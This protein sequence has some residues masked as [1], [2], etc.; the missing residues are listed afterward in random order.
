MDLLRIVSVP[1]RVNWRALIAA[2]ATA[3]ASATASSGEQP[4]HCDNG[5][6]DDGDSLIDPPADPDCESSLD[7]FEGPQV[8]ALGTLGRLALC[9][10]LAV[11]SAWLAGRRPRV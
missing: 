1:F 7:A 2:T 4:M 9:G 5:I 8:P 3:C 6:D 11:A 10:P